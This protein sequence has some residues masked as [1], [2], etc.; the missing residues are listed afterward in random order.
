L[1]VSY[2]PKTE[3]QQLVMKSL[4]CLLQRD[5]TRQYRRSDKGRRVH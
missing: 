5:E 3:Q 4:H 1:S 2:M